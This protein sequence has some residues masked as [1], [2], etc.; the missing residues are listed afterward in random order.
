MEPSTPF[1]DCSSGVETVSAMVLGFAPGY[2]AVT[3]M[4]GGTTSG[5]SLTGS[6]QSAMAPTRKMM[7]DKT[8]AKMG[9][10][11][12]KSEKFMIRETVGRKQSGGWHRR[13]T[14]EEVR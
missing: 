14:P 5:Y 8:P 10:L 12:K 9:R 4:V 3:M 13:T 1:M 7:M 6:S 2:C 11:M